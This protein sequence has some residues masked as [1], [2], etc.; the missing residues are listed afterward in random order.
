[1]PF[2]PDSYGLAPY[3]ISLREGF[4]WVGGYS[5]NPT[6]SAVGL[7]SGGVTINLNPDYTN[8]E[9]DQLHSYIDIVPVLIA[10]TIETRLMELSIW[11]LNLAAGLPES[12]VAGS[13]ILTFEYNKLAERENFH[14]VKLDTLRPPTASGESSGLRTFEFKKCKFTSPGEFY[15]VSRTD[16]TTIPVT[17]NFMADWNETTHEEIFF[18]VTDDAAWTLIDFDGFEE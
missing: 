14:A 17:I 16:V 18:T 4:L 6:Y 2:P 15:A 3:K 8:V 11:H 10:G 7:T 1:M 12:A 13:S 5:A 9:A